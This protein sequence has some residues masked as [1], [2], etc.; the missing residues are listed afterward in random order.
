MGDKNVYTKSYIS[1]NDRF[2]DLCNY[3]LFD[4][5]QVI[6]PEDLTERDVTE[7]GIIF[8]EKGSQ[9]VEKIR[10]L[11]KRCVIKS[12]DKAT[13]LLI[14]IENQSDIHYAMPVRDLVLD[15]LNYAAQADALAKK[16]RKEKD[17]KGVEF[18][19]GFA[20]ND[21]LLPVVTITLYWKAGAWDGP[22]SLH[23]MLEVH[24]PELLRF[25]SDYKMNLIIP[26]EIDDFDKFSTELGAVLR[27]CQ[28][29][30]DKEKLKELV[31]ENKDSGFYLGREAVQVLNECVNAG[32]KE[33]EKEGEV[34]DVCKAVEGLVAESQAKG[35]AK[36]R[37]EG[38]IIM[39][40][41]LV[42]D[43]TLTIHAAAE[44]AK[45]SEE[46]FAKVMEQGYE[47]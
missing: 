25:V 42:K 35:L 31:E 18:L 2:A 45:M 38:G 8:T 33:P 28:C 11:L 19:S 3:F 12:T 14:G 15:A 9:T 20:K 7:K 4:G 30:A 37:K 44:K 13:Y 10:D 34:V 5:R 47:D 40:A 32:L 26:D 39:L 6:Q 17:L 22:R 27:Y 29:S 16:H 46:E 36:G 21:K 43:G 24:E 41:T 23:E 1:R